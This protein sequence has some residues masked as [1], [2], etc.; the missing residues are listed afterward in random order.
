VVDAT[1]IEQLPIDSSLQATYMRAP[2]SEV[3]GRSLS[4]V[5]RCGAFMVDKALQEVIDSPEAAQA[6]AEFYTSVEEGFGTDEELGGRLEVRDFDVRPVVDGHVM[7][8]LK[9]AQ[10]KYKTEAAKNDRRFLPQLIRSGWDHKNALA[11]DKM[12]RG[13]TDYNT[14]IVVTPYVEEAAA[15]S[16]DEYWRH[17]GYVPKYRRGFVQLYHVNGSEVITGSL[18]FD[19]SDKK[20][21]REIFKDFVIEIQKEETTDNWLQYA[22]TDNL[23]ED[24]AK[25]LAT[26]IAD[27]AGDPNYEKSTNTVEVTKKYRPVMERAFSE[28]YIHICESLFRRR[29]TDKTQDI[30]LRFADK[31]HHFN[32]RYSKS[33]YKMRANADQFTDDDAVVLHELLVYSTIEMMRAL[34]LKKSE[35]FSITYERVETTPNYLQTTNDALF[36]N[37][38]SGFG[39]EGAKN[40]RTYSACGLAISLGDKGSKDGPQFAFGG[41][42]DGLSTPL[43][44][45]PEEFGNSEDN[46]E[47]WKWKSGICVVSECPTR[48]RKTKVG[49]CNVCKT[50]QHLFDEGKNPSD[51]YK[52]RRSK[53]AYN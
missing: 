48:P 47:N 12:A 15:Q 49:P 8:N 29:Q 46:K 10:E 52:L 34:H 1:E 32:D 6:R 43:I 7:A 50:C 38:L 21:L 9:C 17:V 36:L 16:G 27:K 51:E 18:S 2:E 23:S 13:E 33:L 14:R 40:N 42:L 26:A 30:I 44:N 39:A 20:R 4:T 3:Y 25:A 53:A 35:T 19:G 37:M 45:K 5:I 31:A 28:S 22:I 11:V 24:Q 41:S